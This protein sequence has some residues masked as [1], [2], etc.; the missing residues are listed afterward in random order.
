MSDLMI[1]IEKLSNLCGGLLVG[2]SLFTFQSANADVLDLSGYASDTCTTSS[3]SSQNWALD[4][5][6]AKVQ[7]G[8]TFQIYTVGTVDCSALATRISVASAKGGLSIGSGECGSAST[9]CV[10]YIAI[11]SAAF[12]GKTITSVLNAN[13][14][15]AY[16]T[17]SVSFSNGG[18][19]TIKLSMSPVQNQQTLAAGTFYDTLFV[20]IGSN[21]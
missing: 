16:G 15:G 7:S 13:G 12:S 4:D 2:L 19:G 11:A 6:K 14:S 1:N 8:A 9:T 17:T 21:L 3:S 5:F 18:T 20:R 10:H